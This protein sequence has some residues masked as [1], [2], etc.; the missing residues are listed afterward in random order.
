MGDPRTG[1]PYADHGTAEQAIDFAIDHAAI[2]A[3][4]FLRSWRE[5][6]LNE[7]PEFYRWLNEV[8]P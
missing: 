1:R 7:W 3:D 4:N 2:E 6:D 5:G 8:Q